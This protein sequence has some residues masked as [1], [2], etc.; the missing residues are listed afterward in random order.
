MSELNTSDPD[1]PD[2]YQP[3]ATSNLSSDLT[4]REVRFDAAVAPEQLVHVAYGQIREMRA[5]A[6]FR[7]AMFLH[8]GAHGRVLTFWESRETLDAFD[9]RIRALPLPDLRFEFEHDEVSTDNPWPDQV[10]ARRTGQVSAFMNGAAVPV[11]GRDVVVWSPPSALRLVEISGL[12]DHDRLLTWW[13]S[14]VAPANPNAI[15]RIPGFQFFISIDWGAGTL[16]GF[17]AFRTDH[18][19]NGYLDSALRQDYALGMS[20]ALGTAGMTS[21]SGSLLAWVLRDFD[22][23]R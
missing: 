17:M 20:D 3:L 16:A 2:N 5:A 13:T 11:A 22:A 10:I 14:I 9:A 18:D 21:Y 8:D 1:R 4:C 12:T 23:C 15:Q 19:L 6:G 7:F